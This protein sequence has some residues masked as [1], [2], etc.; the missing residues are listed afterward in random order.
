MRPDSKPVKLSKVNRRITF[1]SLNS[2]DSH[3]N[4][5]EPRDD[6]ILCSEAKIFDPCSNPD[7]ACNSIE[8]SRHNSS[9][10]N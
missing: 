6:Y 8:P 1:S 3:D 10:L 5:V 2:I 9:E 7:T 4:K